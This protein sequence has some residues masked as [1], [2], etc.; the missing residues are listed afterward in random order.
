MEVISFKSGG[1][2]MQVKQEAK[3]GEN[4]TIIQ[5]NGDFNQGLTGED[6]R[7]ISSEVMRRELGI[8]ASEA[9]QLF[10]ERVEQ[11]TSR[12]IEAVSQKGH[13]LFR[14]FNE[15]AIQLA[16]H[17]VYC[18]YGK[19]GDETLGEGLVELLLE[20][21]EA[22]EGDREQLSLDE[23]L[24]LLPKLTKR[25]VDFLAFFC[26]TQAH[27]NLTPD[28]LMVKVIDIMA[29]VIPSVSELDY[30]DISYLLSV[31]CLHPVP[32]FKRTIHIGEELAYSY[33]RLYPNGISAGILEQYTGSFSPEQVK[34]MF[35]FDETDGLYYFVKGSYQ[36]L[37]DA[38]LVPRHVTESKQIKDL[39][40]RFTKQ[41][42][43][44]ERYYIQRNPLW[45]DI[46]EMW[47]RCSLTQYDL[48][49]PARCIA[50]HALMRILKTAP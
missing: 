29:G 26:F 9:R 44:A 18:E 33:N 48:S 16:L 3:T 2:A 22:K 42:E 12:L 30:R 32:R 46:F 50:G 24:V 36:E 37:V 15:P 17:A 21:L 39:Y 1:I 45:K 25:Q 27:K 8:L 7:R 13:L 31:G 20:R 41:R 11:L 34:A 19:S 35:R 4:S 47:N 38:A 43:D 49:L 10:E 28:D 23:A 40:H 5:V 14:R 6:V